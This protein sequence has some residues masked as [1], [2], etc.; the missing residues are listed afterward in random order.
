MPSFDILVYSATPSGIAAALRAAR[1]EQSVLLVHHH[2]HLGGMM[3]NGLVQWDALSSHR[4]CGVFDEI[5]SRCEDHYRQTCGEGSD[6]HL[7]SKYDSSRYPTGVV[8]PKVF[9]QIVTDLLRQEPNIT[10][11]TGWYIAK[12][13]RR[14]RQVES[15]LLQKMGGEETKEISAKVYIDAGYEGDLAAASGVAYRVGRESH[16]E[17]GEPHAGRLYTNVVKDDGT[18][19]RAVKA[20]GL[21]PFDMVQGPIHPDSPRTGDRCIQAYNF[22]FC[23]TTDPDNRVMVTEPPPGY[24][25]TDYEGYKRLALNMPDLRAI[26]GKTTYNSPILPG[27]NWDY[28]D[29]DWATRWRI[30]EH[31]R[32]F[33]LGLMWFVQNDY[34][35][36]DKDWFEQMRE[37]GLAADE[38]PENNNMPWEMYVR[39]TRRIE[40]RHV[41]TEHDFSPDPQTDQAR[42]FDDSVAFTDWYMDSHSCDI[43]ATYGPEHAFGDEYPYDGK[44]ILN[45]EMRPGQIPYRSLLPVGVDNLLVSVCVGSTHIAWGA[46]RLEPC[47]VHLGESAGAAAALG[48][49]TGKLPGELD[50]QA[51]SEHLVNTGVTV[52]YPRPA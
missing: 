45:A 7:K 10:V 3:T 13:R 40:A 5:L 47:W 14:F 33:A 43:D 42:S 19:A 35:P 29:G 11:M 44:L 4:R 17:F 46:I 2:D 49:R 38:Y 22:R 30:T 25:K 52:R 27:W 23:V 20:A 6:E 51:V 9:E 39:E 37:V 12:A 34:D 16:D 41:L 21:R 15:I 1:D 18:A 24:R 31:H 26:N 36:H 8:E 50:G 28:P 32:N 48:L